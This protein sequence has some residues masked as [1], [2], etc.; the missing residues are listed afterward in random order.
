[1][2]LFDTDHNKIDKNVEEEEH[3]DENEH[4]PVH[5]DHV[6]RVLQHHE[7]SR[8]RGKQSPDRFVV[9]TDVEQELR[10]LYHSHPI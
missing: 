9:I 10:G 7:G 2:V 8:Q 3:L 5:G 6:E 1:M 4:R